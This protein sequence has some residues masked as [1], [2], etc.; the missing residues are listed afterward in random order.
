MAKN[1]R[2]AAEVD[3]VAMARTVEVVDGKARDEGRTLAE[4]VPEVVSRIVAAL[5]PRRIVLFGSVARGDDGPDS[6][7]DLLVVVDAFHDRRHETAVAALRAV[8]GLPVA[9]DVLPATP[10]TIAESGHLPGTLR[11]ALREGRVVH[12]RGA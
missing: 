7:I 5:D 1:D 8:R 3:A 12:E 11:V 10:A 9:V 2:R 4:W 6:D